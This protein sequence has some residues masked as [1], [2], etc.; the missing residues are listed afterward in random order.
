[1]RFYKEIVFFVSLFFYLSCYSHPGISADKKDVYLIGRDDVL[2]ITVWQ[3]PDLT[4]P[5]TVGSDGYFE[6]PILGRIKAEG[7]SPQELE[8]ALYEKL[9]Q[10]YVKEPKVSVAVKEYNS[11]KILVFGEVAKPGLYKLKGEMPLLEL[12]FMVGGVNRDAKRMT[13]IRTADLSANATPAG[14][15]PGSVKGEEELDSSSAAMEVNLIALLSKGDLSQNIMILPGDTIYVSSGTGEKYYVLGQVR[16]P[17]PYE[18]VQEIS[19]LE[20]IKLAEGLTERAAAGRI[21]M[22]R[23][24]GGDVKLNMTAIMKGKK[25]DDV[26][27]RSGDTIIVPESW[28]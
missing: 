10:G 7:L 5:V 2:D 11:K 17:G 28:I 23:Q 4:K 15:L 16:K 3:S 1:M 24:R 26:M 8:K 22:R 19:V 27:V 18:W 25:K 13:V 6:Y 12:L 14:L 9:A 20:A 21:K